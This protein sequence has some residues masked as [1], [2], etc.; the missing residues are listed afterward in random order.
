MDKVIT[1]NQLIELTKRYRIHYLYYLT[2]IY[3]LNSIV[4]YGILSNIEAHERNLVVIDLS[5]QEVQRIR[6]NKIVRSHCLHEYA[7]LY[8]S[9]RNPMLCKRQEMQSE[10]IILC[11]SPS[12]LLMENSVFSDGNAASSTTKFYYKLEHLAKLPWHIIHSHY[13]QNHEDGSRIKC[14]EVLIYPRISP[15][16]ITKIY[17]YT[18][19]TRLSCMRNLRK[20]LPVEINQ[21]L[22]F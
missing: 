19:G 4:S 18:E 1:K 7:C 3:H 12:I 20:R 6:R 5:L 17:C 14:A 2:S 13:W 22:Y 10:I 8:F 11:V 21:S 16:F 9:P 15:E